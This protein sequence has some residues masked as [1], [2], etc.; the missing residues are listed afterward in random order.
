MLLDQL[1]L[2]PFAFAVIDRQALRGEVYSGPDILPPKS[3]R[4]FP[5]LIQEADLPALVHSA[6]EVEAPRSQRD[7]VGDTAPLPRC[8]FSAFHSSLHFAN[9]QTAQPRRR[10]AVIPGEKLRAFP[11]EVGDGGKVIFVKETARPEMIDAFDQGITVG[12]AGGNEERLHTQVEQHPD[13]PSEHPG[14]S[15]QIG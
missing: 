14:L 4:D 2:C 5:A 9:A 11:F 6:D 8:Q 1:R 3:P 12:L 10:I 15:A 13:E 7:W